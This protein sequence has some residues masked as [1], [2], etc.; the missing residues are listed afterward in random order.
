ML[1]AGWA[2]TYEQSGAEYGK[3]GKEEFLKLEAEAK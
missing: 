1:R 3:W 2:I